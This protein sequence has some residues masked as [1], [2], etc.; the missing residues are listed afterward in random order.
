MAGAAA[1]PAVVSPTVTVPITINGA[2]NPEETGKI[3][4]KHVGN[5]V[6]E[7]MEKQAYR[8]GSRSAKSTLGAPATE[9]PR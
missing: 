6:R 3:A 4:A 7:V 2:P 5:V 1:T 9:A 8:S